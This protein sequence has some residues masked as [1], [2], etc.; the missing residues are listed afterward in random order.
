MALQVV[1]ME[2]DI[3]EEYLLSFYCFISWLLLPDP[4]DGGRY[5][6]EIHGVTIQNTVIFGF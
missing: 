6:S 2:A 4:E 5:L 3:S 1:P